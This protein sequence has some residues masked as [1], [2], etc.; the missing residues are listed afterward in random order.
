MG[1]VG[2]RVVAGMGNGGVDGSL[3]PDGVGGRMTNT[4]ADALAG[5][6]MA[7]VAVSSGLSVVDGW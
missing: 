5:M 3:V 4:V 7:V 1:C 2:G 6:V